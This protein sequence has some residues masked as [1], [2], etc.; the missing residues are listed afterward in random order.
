[1]EQEKAEYDR[2]NPLISAEITSVI[3]WGFSGIRYE[4]DLTNHSDRV[5]RKTEIVI[6]T[7]DENGD[8]IDFVRS[9]RDIKDEN[10]K[11]V[12]NAE[13]DLEYWG[14]VQPGET[15]ESFGHADGDAVKYKICVRSAEFED[16]ETWENPYFKVWLSEEKDRY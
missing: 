12:V 15:K 2:Q 16:G 7:F 1:M 13:T 8:P 14:G 6:L 3:T 10:G 4:Y 9:A 5:L 11:E